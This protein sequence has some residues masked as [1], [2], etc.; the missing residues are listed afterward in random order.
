M[1]HSSILQRTRELP[2]KEAM[3]ALVIAL[4]S[5]SSEFYKTQISYRQ[6]SMSESADSSLLSNR[7]TES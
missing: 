5:Y 1:L 6:K 4:I 7:E 3:W 2:P